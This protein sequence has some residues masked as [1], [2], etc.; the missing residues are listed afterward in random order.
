MVGVMGGSMGGCVNRKVARWLD[1]WMIGKA[2]D[3]IPEQ[4]IDEV[5][6]LMATR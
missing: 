6:G 4:C 5:V 3:L 2:A 1:A